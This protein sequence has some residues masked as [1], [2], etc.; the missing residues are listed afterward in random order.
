MLALDSM[1]QKS[2]RAMTPLDA[3]TANELRVKLGRGRDLPVE[4][5]PKRVP[6]P[7]AVPVEGEAAEPAA[8]K[9][10]RKAAGKSGG[11]TAKIEAEPAPILRLPGPPPRSSGPRPPL[12]RRPDP[13]T[14]RPPPP[15]CRP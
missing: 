4:A 7:K 10:P 1:G 6:K 12:P 13:A 2:M 15:R 8:P 3:A 11:K 5:K 9:A 14:S